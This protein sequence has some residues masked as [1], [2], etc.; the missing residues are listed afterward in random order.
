MHRGGIV[1]NPKSWHAYKS[2]PTLTETRRAIAADA[3]SKKPAGKIGEYVY[4]NFGYM[5]AGL[6]A[7]KAT[8][9]PWEQLMKEEV[10]SPLGIT[11]FG[12]GPPGTKDKTDQPW[13]HITAL[14]L[15]TPIQGD[16]APALGPAGTVHMSME[17]WAKF[18]RQH[19]PAKPGDNSVRLIK[20]RDA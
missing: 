12:F 11:S 5:I 10:F 20:G 9:K 7:N 19:L 13:G 18:C 8:G 4:S 16:N 6:I 3:L 15:T 14:G 1:A 2:R 17:D